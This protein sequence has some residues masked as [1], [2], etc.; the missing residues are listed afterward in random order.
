M[1]SLPDLDLLLEKTSR[2]F[3]LSIPLLPEPTRREVTI[4]YLLFRIADT[5]E[6]AAVWTRERRRSALAEFDQLLAAPDAGLARRL[7]QEW[8]RE[9]PSAHAGYLEL[10]AEV[11]AVLD[12]FLELSP[13]ARRIIGHHTRR[14]TRGM[15]DFVQRANDVGDLE[16]RDMD[17]LVEY[18]YIVAGIVGELLTDLFLLDRSALTAAGPAL[19]ARARSFGEGLQ[20]TNILKDAADDAVEGRRFLPPGVQLEQV[21]ERARQDL[22]AATEYVQTL[23][24]SGA[25]HGLVAFTAL[26]VRL[27]WAT[28]DRVEARGAGAKLTRE[29]VF[30]IVAAMEEAIGAERPA[31]EVPAA[32]SS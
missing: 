6:D 15:A 23:Q 19:A 22:V 7:A 1:T 4:A 25:E 12:A 27:A 20:L 28:L 11:P 16:L 3:A 17:D 24:R 18:C 29:E 10:V 5:F 8:R 32:L 2:T 13:Q 9:L 30:A 14:T 21:F 31:V 26:P